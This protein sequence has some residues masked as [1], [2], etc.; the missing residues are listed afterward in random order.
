MVKRVVLS[1]PSATGELVD[2]IYELDTAF[3]NR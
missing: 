1:R 3:A 2:Q